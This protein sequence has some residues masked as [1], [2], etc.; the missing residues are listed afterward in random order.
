MVSACFYGWRK[1]WG[2][3]THFCR[4]GQVLRPFSGWEEGEEGLLGMASKARKKHS[5]STVGGC[6]AVRG[7]C[8]WDNEKL[9]LKL[10]EV[11]PQR[12]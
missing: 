11:F 4:V 8:R 6:G 12:R 10:G 7:I 1:A 5:N 9:T 2:T 3:G